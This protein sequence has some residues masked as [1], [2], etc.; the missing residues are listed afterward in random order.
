M[1]TIP[2]PEFEIGSLVKIE[3]ETGKLVGYFIYEEKWYYRIAPTFN[4]KEID[5]LEAPGSK[6]TLLQPPSQKYQSKYKVGHKVGRGEARVCGVSRYE[7]GFKYYVGFLDSAFCDVIRWES[8][9]MVD[10]MVARRQQLINSGEIIDN[11]E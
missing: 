8:E 1:N 7:K 4:Y 3:E 2:L 9:D 10:Q 5:V 11:F 6:I